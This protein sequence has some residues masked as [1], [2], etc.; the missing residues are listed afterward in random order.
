MSPFA[1]AAVFLVQIHVCR[2]KNPCKV[3]NLARIFALHGQIFTQKTAWQSQW[4][5]HP[6]FRLPERFGQPPH[7]QKEQ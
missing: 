2:V 6:V 1:Y 5:T 3:S 4:G 7:I